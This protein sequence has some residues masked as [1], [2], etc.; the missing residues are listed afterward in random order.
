MNKDEIIEKVYYDAAGYGSV[1]ETLKDAK[2]FNKAITYEEVNKWKDSNVERKRK[3]FGMNSFI[4]HEA[5]EEFQMDLMFF[6]DLQ[7]KYNG[8][9][10]IVE[11]FSKYT[12]VIPV[13]GKTTEE[14]LDALI[15][16]LGKMHGKPKVIYSDNEPCFS[17]VAI[18][19]ISQRPPYQ[20][21]H[22]IG[23]CPRGREANTYDKRHDI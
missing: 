9:L 21:H 17:S 22:N 15:L 20:T 13:H 8:G 19:K 10:L 11:I 16:G 2:L 5:F 14:V 7:E 3:L 4:A 23:S 18:H 12:T 6:A 1:K